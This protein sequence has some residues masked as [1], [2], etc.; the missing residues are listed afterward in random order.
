MATTF[1]STD[2]LYALGALLG[3]VTVLYF[4]V[5]IVLSFAPAVKSVVL[6]LSFVAFFLL[7]IVATR[8]LAVVCYVLAAATYLVFLGYTLVRFAFGTDAI[9][10]SLAA[11]S[12]LFV[13]LGYLV[14]ER[15]FGTSRRRVGTALLVVLVLVAAVSAFDVLGAKPTYTLELDEEA[16]LSTRAYMIPIGTV[17]AKNDFVLSRTA[18]PPSYEV[19]VYTPEKRRAYVQ[20]GNLYGGSV[21]LDSGESREFKVRMEVPPLPGGPTAGG[22]DTIPVERAAECPET[23]TEPKIVVVER[24]AGAGTPTYTSPAGGYT[25]T[26]SGPPAEPSAPTGTSVATE[27]TMKRLSPSSPNGTAVSADTSSGA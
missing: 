18:E 27:T 19:C 11:S 17:T 10:L 24:P 1:R 2:V 16:D 4:S 26:A 23:S 13:G 14:R 21:L 3:V 9:F 20:T 15:G 6:V 5:E 8:A 12:V 25:V 7:A 22:F